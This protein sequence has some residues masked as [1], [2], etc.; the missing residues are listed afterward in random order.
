MERLVD[1]G[2]EAALGWRLV[3]VSREHTAAMGQMAE[4][5]HVKIG[6]AA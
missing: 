5:M 1:V 3:G 2:G 4:H 6:V